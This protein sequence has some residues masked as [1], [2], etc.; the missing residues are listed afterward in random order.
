MI[1]EI[2]SLQLI[3]PQKVRYIM[4]SLN[5]LFY[6]DSKHFM[7]Y[8]VFLPSE[9]VNVAPEVEGDIDHCAV[10]TSNILFFVILFIFAVFET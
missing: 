9:R 8:F 1:M 2:I 4:L 7:Q 5:S 6:N 3:T 10:L